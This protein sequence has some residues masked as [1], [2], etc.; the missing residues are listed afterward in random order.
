[1][2]TTK[3]LV[4]V[5]RSQERQVAKL[6]R[7]LGRKAYQL[8]QARA[9]AKAIPVLDEHKVETL[10]EGNRRLHEAR[11]A[12]ERDVRALRSI[13]RDVAAVLGCG[14]QELL[15]RA[16]RRV[17]QEV[18]QLKAQLEGARTGRDKALADWK[19]VFDASGCPDDGTTLVDWL[20]RMRR[21]RD[22]A[23]ELAMQRAE[24]VRLAYDR[25]DGFRDTVAEKDTLIVTLRGQCSNAE[26]A[27]R[28]AVED[29][30]GAEEERDEWQGKATQYDRER[31][32]AQRELGE[33]NS[34][35]RKWKEEHDQMQVRGNHLVKAYDDMMAERDEARE[36]AAQRGEQMRQ[37]HGERDD[38]REALSE[39]RSA[40]DWALVREDRMLKERD[41]ARRLLR[42]HAPAVFEHEGFEVPDLNHVDEG[43]E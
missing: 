43:G 34:S 22:E 40:R 21:Q 30:K 3:E 5:I 39:M 36:L 20:A 8:N 29:R 18:S 4:D 12:A 15:T 2:S 9:E 13:K 33:A 42:E 6:E 7:R 38:L 17:V 28:E 23:Q 19:E 14:P 35:A 26:R 31:A 24:Q 10:Q 11:N 41:A 32:Q 27:R 37:L 25:R 1:M 16:A